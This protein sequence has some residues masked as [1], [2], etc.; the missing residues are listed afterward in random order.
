M[1]GITISPTFC[2]HFLIHKRKTN[3]HWHL[4]WA[5][6]RAWTQKLGKKKAG[7]ALFIAAIPW[8]W[9]GRNCRSRPTPP[10]TYT[11]QIKT[12]G[13]NE[14]DLGCE[15]NWHISENLS[16]F[17]RQKTHFQ[18]H[19]YSYLFISFLRVLIFYCH[20]TSPVFQVWASSG[21]N[22]LLIHKDL[23]PT[24]K[25]RFIWKKNKDHMLLDHQQGS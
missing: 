13:G 19:S 6:L 20:S 3:A 14:S 25:L 18:Y 22:N 24:S 12:M 11:M 16:R 21:W 23:S 9:Q 5:G 17:S 7:V 2:P 1:D 15:W 8:I 4:Q 10:K